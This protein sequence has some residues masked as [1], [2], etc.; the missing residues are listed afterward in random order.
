MAAGG[1]S[2]YYL[3]D[4]SGSVANLT[5]TEGVTEWTYSFEPFG[6]TKSETPNDPSAPTNWMKFAAEYADPTSLLYYLRARQYDPATGRF[7]AMD[8]VSAGAAAGTVSAYAYSDNRPAVFADPTGATFLPIRDG[9]LAAA[10]ATS[11]GTDLHFDCSDCGGRT[12]ERGG[13]SAD[14]AIKRAEE[15]NKKP[16][17]AAEYALDRILGDL[18]ADFEGQPYPN[19]KG[20]LD[21]LAKGAKWMIDPT[22]KTEEVGTQYIKPNTGGGVKI[23]LMTGNPRAGDPVHR[24]PRVRVSDGTIQGPNVP[25]KPVRP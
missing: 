21:K 12:E 5:S 13:E 18:G 19:V 10:D 17:A 15:I 14:E 3:Y 23:R 22:T 6:A 25:L 1:T 9:E 4:V 8:P 2:H 7:T 16:K 11:A 24:N 20:L